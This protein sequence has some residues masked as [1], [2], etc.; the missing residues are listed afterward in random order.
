LNAVVAALIACQRG[1]TPVLEIATT[2][3]VVNSG[4]LDTLL[5]RFT[6]AEARY[7]V[8]CADWLS[9]GDGRQVIATYHVAGR[10]AFTAWPARCIANTPLALPCK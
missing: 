8:E 3:S 10:P 7:A 1:T 2:T 6:A 5:P 9:D 4:L